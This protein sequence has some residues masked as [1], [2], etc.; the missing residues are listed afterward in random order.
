VLFV[1][2]ERNLKQNVPKEDLVCQPPIKGKV[3]IKVTTLGQDPVRYIY[4]KFG[5][6]SCIRS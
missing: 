4:A 6:D 5:V 3:A 2:P 1:N